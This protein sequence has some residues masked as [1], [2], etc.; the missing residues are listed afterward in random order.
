MKVQLVA[1]GNK[2][3]GWVE[4]GYKEYSKRL[5]RDLNPQLVEIP[6]GHRGKNASISDAMTKESASI[7]K[8]IPQQNIKVML[9]TQG[10][11]WS[12]EQLARNL[13]D[14][15]MT[16]RDVSFVIG[17]PDGFSDDCISQADLKWCLS[18]LTLP[19]PI[20]RIVF[21]EQLYRAWTILQNHPYHK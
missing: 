17:G 8:A 12:T 16:G 10:K 3:P 13:A 14:W 7:L 11:S 2:M 5:P 9:H 21:I 20:V 6:V 4:Q 1:V 15:Q 19:H 18:D